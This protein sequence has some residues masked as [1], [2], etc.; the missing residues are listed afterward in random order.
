ME[1]LNTNDRTHVL[2]YLLHMSSLITAILEIGCMLEICEKGC[3]TEKDACYNVTLLT[4]TI[5]RGIGVNVVSSN[6]PGIVAMLSTSRDVDLKSATDIILRLAQRNFL[7]IISSTL[8]KMLELITVDGEHTVYELYPE[9]I[10]KCVPI[11]GTTHY[12]GVLIRAAE[13]FAGIKL[14]GKYF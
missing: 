8:A 10:I 9:N 7:I 1:R 5:V 2:H 14:C 4:D 11:L 13:I 6:V 3:I 12:V